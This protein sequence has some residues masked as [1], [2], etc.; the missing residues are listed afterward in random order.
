MPARGEKLRAIHGG[1][2]RLHWRANLVCNARKHRDAEDAVPWRIPPAWGD[3]L[4]RFQKAGA[5]QPWI[6]SPSANREGRFRVR[7]E[8]AS[9][10][11]YARRVNRSSKPFR[12]N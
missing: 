5:T 3:M 4:C 1:A 9:K 11:R 2:A 6:A 8:A 7:R 12:R 10:D